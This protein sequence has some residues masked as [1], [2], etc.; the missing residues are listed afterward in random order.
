MI[1]SLA[2][3][4]DV[5]NATSDSGNRSTLPKSATMF[6]K[7]KHFSERNIPWTSTLAPVDDKMLS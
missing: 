1:P 4:Y 5:L 2:I 6:K 7:K 3:K